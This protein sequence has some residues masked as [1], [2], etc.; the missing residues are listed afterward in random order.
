MF[1][2]FQMTFQECSPWQDPGG[3][4]VKGMEAPSAVVWP[5][6]VVMWG[7]RLQVPL[8]ALGGPAADVGKW[9]RNLN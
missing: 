6:L 1:L 4:S 3:L 7:L 9:E 5:L 2:I 8:R